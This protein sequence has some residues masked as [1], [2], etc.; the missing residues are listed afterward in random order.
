MAVAPATGV[1][2]LTGH[3]SSQLPYFL[4][5]FSSK[6][7]MDGVE[8]IECEHDSCPISGWNPNNIGVKIA[9]VLLGILHILSRYRVQGRSDAFRKGIDNGELIESSSL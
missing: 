7:E 2:M 4:E 8:A 6:I 1:K 3:H 5:E 9:V